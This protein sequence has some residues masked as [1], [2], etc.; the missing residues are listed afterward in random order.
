MKKTLLRSL[1]AAAALMAVCVSGRSQTFEIDSLSY[2]VLSAEQKTVAV[3]GADINLVNAVIPE[4]VTNEGVTYTV[5]E[6]QERGFDKYKKLLTVDLPKTIVKCGKHT[7]NECSNLK[8]TIIH[9]VNAWVK[10]D[11]S[12]TSLA[13]PGYKSENLYLGDKLLEEVVITEPITQINVLCFYYIK[14]IKKVVLPPTVTKIGKWG[15]YR[16]G[17]EEINL[18]EALTTSEDYAFQYSGLKHLEMPDNWTVMKN[19]TFLENLNLKS[20]KLPANMKTLPMNTFQK[21]NA[22]ESVIFNE[23][24]ELIKKGAFVATAQRHVELP[25]SLTK[26]ENQAFLDNIYLETIKIGPNVTQIGYLC[27]YVQDDTREQFS[28]TSPLRSITCEATVPPV[29]QMTTDKNGVEYNMAWNDE[30]YTQATLYVPKGCVDAYR[31]APEWSRFTKIQEINSGIDGVEAECGVS[32]STQG[33][34]III[35]GAESP[36]VDV[37]DAS[38]RKVYTGTGN[39]IRPALKGVFVVVCEGVSAKIAL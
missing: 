32:I 22:L 6:T 25:K 10:I 34:E 28:W 3:K 19:G 26:I 27:F 8:K 9:D 33:E 11:F 16:C 17:V 18:P 2:T 35:E 1:S 30:V 4:T 38:G 24:L 36:R 21:C 37:Y 29:L 31:Q 14:T 7:F 15:F 20:V 12:N 13:N 39:R 23:G 5:T